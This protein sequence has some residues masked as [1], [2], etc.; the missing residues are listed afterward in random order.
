MLHKKY[1]YQICTVAP[2]INLNEGFMVLFNMNKPRGK[3]PD[4]IFCRADFPYLVF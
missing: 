1:Y 3:K 2:L 4:I